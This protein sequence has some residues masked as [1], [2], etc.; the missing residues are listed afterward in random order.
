MF[1][2][3]NWILIAVGLSYAIGIMA[4]FVVPTNRKPGEA[5]AWLMLI[6]LV[7]FLGIVLFL[8]LGSPKLSKRRRVRQRTMDEFLRKTIADGRQVPELQTLLHP[9]ILPRYEPF[10]RLNTNLGGLPPFAGNC[11]ELL[12]DY[13]DAIDRIIQAIE[14][15][16]HYIH[17]EYF[18]FA[19]DST[20]GKVI[21]ALISAQQRGVVCRV[22]ID[23]IGNF[24]FNRPV[25][26]RLQAGGVAV[27]LILPVRILDQE[28]SRLDLRNHRKIV[29]VD[30]EIGFTGSQNLIDSNYH[31]PSNLKKGLS[32]IELVARVTGPVVH[33][34]NAAFTTDWYS[35]TGVLLD[36]TTAPETRV[37]VMP[38]ATGAV[39]CQV[40]PS[41]PGFEN[42]NNLKLFVALF[43]AARRT[44]TIANPYFVPDDALMLALTS[45][46][47]RGVDVTLIV[48]EIGDQFLVYHAQHS[49]YE[50]L[51]KAGVQVYQYQSPVLL[52]T[53]ILSIDDDIAVIGSSNMDLRSFQLNLEVTL[54]CYDK[55]VVVETQQVF[56]DYLR[57]SRVLRLDEWQARPI[58]IKLF[59]NLARLTSA[60]Q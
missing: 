41:G 5:A 11:V 7:P 9:P 37:T 12:P 27:H 26:S 10:V 46:A 2:N 32:Y 42:D 56:A 38:R 13:G 59:D 45:A 57:H 47:Q 51:L 15:A 36:A 23:H 39:V 49:Y 43:H 6:F 19:D 33:Q 29:V 30:G 1:W 52:H 31:K 60:L 16:H 35:E 17:V 34:F 8:L 54:V 25:L 53:K 58:L 18:I 14:G 40:L 20:G 4:L 24:R 55:S 50:E 28:W 22:L 48:S 21:D 3:S 44:I